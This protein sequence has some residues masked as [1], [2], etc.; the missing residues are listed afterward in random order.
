MRNQAYKQA[1]MMLMSPLLPLFLMVQA[2]EAA[3]TPVI[4]T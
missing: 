2:G 4:P 1:T 3:K